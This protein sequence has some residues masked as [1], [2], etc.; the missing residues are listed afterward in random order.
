MYKRQDQSGTITEMPT[1]TASAYK[2][3]ATGIITIDLSSSDV[4]PVHENAQHTKG[5]SLIH[6]FNTGNR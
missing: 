5:L 3:L 6:I 1:I 4:V 2:T